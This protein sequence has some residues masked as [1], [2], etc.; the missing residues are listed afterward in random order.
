MYN[1]YN[2]T[3]SINIPVGVMLNNI[4]GKLDTTMNNT[5][6]IHAKLCDT[7]NVRIKGDN[8]IILSPRTQTTTR[9]THTTKINPCIK[10]VNI[11]TCKDTVVSKASLIKK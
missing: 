1:T 6:K 2:D 7:I 9:Q 3:T 11:D 4:E 5:A 10:K 8:K